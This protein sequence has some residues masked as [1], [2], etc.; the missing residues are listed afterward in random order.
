MVLAVACAGLPWCRT[1][2][3][4]YVADGTAV[5]ISD[6]A[7]TK[8]HAHL[9][10]VVEEILKETT[11]D[12][13]FAAYLDQHPELMQELGAK[14]NQDAIEL[15]RRRLEIDPSRVGGKVTIHF[16]FFAST[17]AS[18]TEVMSQY[19]QDF[20]GKF[21]AWKEQK[22]S[23]ITVAYTQEVQSTQ[24]ELKQVDGDLQKYHLT[25]TSP[26]TTKT[27]EAAQPEI[28]P[29][30]ATLSADLKEARQALQ[31]LLITRTERHPL[32]IDQ[33]DKI[34]ALEK[35]LASTPK[36]M[37]P[38]KKVSN[39]KDEPIGAFAAER[40]LKIADLEKQRQE[41][42][43]RLVSLEHRKQ[44]T[45]QALGFIQGIH[46]QTPGDVARVT[47]VGG[48]WK[49][50]ALLVLSGWMIFFGLIA[51]QLAWSA[52][53]PVVIHSLG[54][55]ASATMV[56][57]I[58]T[59]TMTGSSGSTPNGT[60]LAGPFSFLLTRAAELIVIGIL[61]LVVLAAQSQ[62]ELWDLLSDDPL[63]VVRQS[64]RILFPASQ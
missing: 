9:Q 22:S 28:S 41:L 57:V 5:V 40:Q 49:M 3:A 11:D 55:L 48:V 2:Q 20:Q 25:V 8:A 35:E 62:P 50:G 39:A 24:A 23:A 36:L 61:G 32:V 4:G 21:K 63:G 53:R 31:Q 38:A 27:K 46:V 10:Q 44:D 30:W 58:A 56:P 15:F 51:Y 64:L 54:K 34:A 52:S 18:C 12:R 42:Q 37:F 19:L 29:E 16:R 33:N 13:K 43:S 6:S 7:E 60:S 59:M 45:E 14:T 1:D 26:A 17:R 47:P